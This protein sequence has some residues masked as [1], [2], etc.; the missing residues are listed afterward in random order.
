MSDRFRKLS[1]ILGYICIAICVLD[2]VLTCVGYGAYSKE[3]LIIP[4][5][6]IVVCSVS[7][8]INKRHNKK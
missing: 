3:K 4:I 1:N 5:V 7:I 8:T 6:M 2:I